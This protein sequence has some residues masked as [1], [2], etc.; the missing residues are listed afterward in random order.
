MAK[1]IA[2]LDFSLDDFHNQKVLRGADAYGRLIQ[3]LLFMRKGTYPTIPDM[4]VDIASY[5][6]ADLDTLTAGELKNTIR[7]QCDTYIDG[8]PIQ[9]INISVVKIPSGYVL[10]ID[11]MVVGELRKISISILQDGYEIINTSLKV[12]KPKLINV[13]RTG[14]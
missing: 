12:E 2:E 5:R 14:A 7:H 13:P 3:R 10:F 4:G 1:N 9:D 6:F 8:V 11:I